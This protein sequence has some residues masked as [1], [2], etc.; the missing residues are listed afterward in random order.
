MTGN[1]NK[2][3]VENVMINKLKPTNSSFLINQRMNCVNITF[4][5]R[6]EITKI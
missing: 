3:S 4:I 6:G 2:Q 5:E 1:A